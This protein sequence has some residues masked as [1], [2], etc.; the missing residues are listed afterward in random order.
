MRL[1]TSVTA[2]SIV[3]AVRCGFLPMAAAQE[4]DS[5][6]QPS[7]IRDAEIEGF[8]RTWWTPILRAASLDPQAVHIY[9]VADPEINSFV[10][11]GQ[12]LFMNT[13]TLLRSKTPNQI[14]GIMAHETGH[15]A[16]DARRSRE[17]D[18]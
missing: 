15:I 9:L 10:A 8:I 17:Q 16:D 12:N 18:D 13:G 6:G 14:I 2:L 3:P 7:L 5:G 11:G 1:R 4:S